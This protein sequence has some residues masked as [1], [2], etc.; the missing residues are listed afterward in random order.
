MKVAIKFIPVSEVKRYNGTSDKGSYSIVTW[1]VK[2][3]DNKEFV[4]NCFGDT[5]DYMQSHHEATIDGEIEIACREYNG[6]FY[7]DVKIVKIEKEQEEVSDSPKH[8]TSTSITSINANNGFVNNS[9]DPNSANDLP[10]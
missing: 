10:F 6:N 9:L 4:V 1:K 8:A 5:S 7:N 3:L 2:G